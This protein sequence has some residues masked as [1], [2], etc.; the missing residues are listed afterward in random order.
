[1]RSEDCFFKIFPRAAALFA[2]TAIFIAGCAT[3]DSTTA[4]VEVKEEAEISWQ[5]I[6]E[7]AG[8]DEPLELELTKRMSIVAD[9][10][11]EQKMALDSRLYKFRAKN[12]PV[13]K[14]LDL[15]ARAN[16]LNIIASPDVTGNVT[17]SFTGL[18]FKKAMEAILDV[19]GYYWETR[20]NLVRVYKFETKLFT[21]DYVRLVREGSGSSQAQISSST[22]GGGQAGEVTIKQ[23]D[24][25]DFWKDLKEQLKIIIG[26]DEGILAINRLSGTIQVTA[27]HQVVEKVGRY[28]DA[29]NGSIMRQVEI[30]VRILE[31][32]LSDEF[33]LGID[34]NQTI[35]DMGTGSISTSNIITASVGSVLPK[36]ATVTLS[37]GVLGG[38]NF[39]AVI[40]AL[41]EQGDVRVVSKPM[42]RVMN[43]QPALIK[44]GTDIPFFQS[45]TTPGTGGSAPIVTEEVRY[46]TAGMVLSITPQISGDGWIMLDVTPTITRLAGTVLSPLGSTAPTMEIKQSSTIVRL[47]DGETVT[48]GG[49]IQTEKSEKVRKVPILGDIPILGY[50]FR[51]KYTAD[52]NRELV[53]FLTPRIIKDF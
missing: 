36:P 51:G 25:V 53:V 35:D 5:A 39:N 14:A 18:A 31:V 41:R 28:I 11:N 24:K 52:I 9:E 10:A 30:E 3:P 46:I 21:I 12:M 50:L 1:M 13:K 33:S 22:G 2:V 32:T 27:R 16:S 40:T 37:Y 34:W 19:H 42:I 20:E 45:T 7:E 29:I 23:S 17:V 8:K 38:V 49:L 47:R 43:N 6:Q 15:F 48:I 44:V 26:P 4:K